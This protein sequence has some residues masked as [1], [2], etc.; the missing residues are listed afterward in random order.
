MVGAGHPTC[1]LA[2]HAR[3]AHE[4]VLY[5]FVEHMPHVQNAC[6]IGGRYYYGVGFAVIGFRAEKFVFQPV[7]IPFAL[8]FRG[9]VFA[10]EFHRDVFVVLHCENMLLR[11][12]ILR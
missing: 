3:A 1:V 9:A 10:C 5:S 4:D 2:L 11:R 7:F 12:N 6:H 8:Y